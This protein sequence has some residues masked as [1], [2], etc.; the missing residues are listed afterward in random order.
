MIYLLFSQWFKEQPA[1]L[2]WFLC[3]VLVAPTLYES[4]KAGHAVK[5]P[6]VRSVATGL[7][8]PYTGN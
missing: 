3:C 4:F 1:K 5:I 2:M 8:P 7:M 6:S